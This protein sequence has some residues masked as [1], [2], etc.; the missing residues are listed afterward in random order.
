MLKNLFLKLSEVGAQLLGSAAVDGILPTLR[1]VPHYFSR[2]AVKVAL[3]PAP[4]REAAF[5]W[6]SFFQNRFL[7]TLLYVFLT[8]FWNLTF[9]VLP[10]NRLLTLTLSGI[11]KTTS[12]GMA[13]RYMR[14]E[15]AFDYEKIK[16]EVLKGLAIYHAVGLTTSILSDFIFDNDNDQ[17][18]QS[19]MVYVLGGIAGEVLFHY[20]AKAADKVCA[21]LDH[22]QHDKEIAVLN[23]VRAPI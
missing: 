17:D 23:R 22:N 18:K 2:E 5:S 12:A 10:Q 6:S 14:H 4:P 20:S 3:N 1:T 9:K 16:Q 8:S 7:D 19:A 15:T 21:L 13:Y 11:I